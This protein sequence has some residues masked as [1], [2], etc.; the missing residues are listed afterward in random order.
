MNLKEMIWSAIF[1]F[2]II[3]LFLAFV[4][5][6]VASN[7]EFGISENGIW[8][9]LL[10]MQQNISSVNATWNVPVIKDISLG[11]TTSDWIGIG[12]VNN[13]Q[14][15]QTGVST[16]SRLSFQK[17]MAWYELFPQSPVLLFHVNPNDIIRAEITR[18]NSTNEW[19]LS[20]NDLTNHKN[21][22]NVF[23]FNIS[24]E[25][26]TTAE[27]ILEPQASYYNISLTNFTNITTKS[28][29]KNIPLCNT[30]YHLSNAIFA[31]WENCNSQLEVR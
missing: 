22:S 21:F 26:D 6:Y 9:G 18:I 15:I 20:I 14:L 30:T 2:T 23:N 31:K 13:N 19:R 29:F 3:L 24:S 1:T 12:G 28:K 27:Y 11:G 5:P 10:I 17:N 25:N 8:H 7:P 16:G 4:L